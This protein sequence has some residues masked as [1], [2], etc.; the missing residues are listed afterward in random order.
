MPRPGGGSHT[1][2]RALA[3]PPPLPLQARL[4][5]WKPR[6]EPRPGRASRW[7]GVE[8]PDLRGSP[9]LPRSTRARGL[10][11]A[12]LPAA[13]PQ[14][15]SQW[16][17]KV[18][19]AAPASLPCPLGFRSP[20]PASPSRP[21]IVEPEGRVSPFVPTLG[22]RPSQWLSPFTWTPR[23]QPPPQLSVGWRCVLEGGGL[24]PGKVDRV[25]PLGIPPHPP[26]R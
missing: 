12:A 26:P 25:L 17:A 19:E 18:Q 20:T 16:L 23:A 2:I 6:G 13:L 11:Q 22:Q 21:L 9:G 4:G 15:R 7:S 5:Q 8:D 3:P 1:L 10:A 24:G 14:N